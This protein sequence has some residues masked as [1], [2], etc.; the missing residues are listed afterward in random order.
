MTHAHALLRPRGRPVR[1]RLGG[2]FA[3]QATAMASPRPETSPADTPSLRPTVMQRCAEL[4]FRLTDKRRQLVEVFDRV[5]A[6][7]DL[8]EAWWKAVE[9]ELDVNRSS[10]HRLAADLVAAGVLNEIGPADRRARFATPLSPTVEIRATGTAPTVVED[11]T[12]SEML[13]ETLAKRGLDVTQRRIVITVLDE[14]P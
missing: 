5:S 13:V 4:N 2:R 10:L 1:P 14:H 7:I 3:S 11:P 8:D 9:L 6:P 12:L